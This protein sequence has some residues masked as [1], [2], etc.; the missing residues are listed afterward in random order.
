M[1]LEEHLL[2][3]KT[4]IHSK[5]DP[6][7]PAF[8]PLLCDKTLEV[9]GRRRMEPQMRVLEVPDTGRRGHTANFMANFCC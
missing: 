3:L 9:G 8:L 5:A 2:L 4:T 6:Q 7:L 1:R